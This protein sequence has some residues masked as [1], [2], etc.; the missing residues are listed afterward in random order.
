[1]QK[2]Y[3]T[4][5]PH[6]NSRT[7]C[8]IIACRDAGGEVD[9]IMLAHIRRRHAVD[10]R[11]DSLAVPVIGERGRG[12]AADAGQAILHVP[13]LGIRHA[14]LDPPCHIPVWIVLVRPSIRQ[15]CDRVLVRRVRVPVT[16]QRAADAPG[17]VA[18][19]VEL[20]GLGILPVTHAV[21][22]GHAKVCA[23]VKCKTG[24]HERLAPVSTPES[25]NYAQ[26]ILFI[27]SCTCRLIGRLLAV[28]D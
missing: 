2:G 22:G 18:D 20:V 7:A 14:A 19:G 15:P 13:R 27:R 5:L 26:Q 24:Q 28:F 23:V 17:D 9:L 6:G 8:V 16:R 1:M 25:Y 3:H 11:L 12:P 21:G 4:C 10:G